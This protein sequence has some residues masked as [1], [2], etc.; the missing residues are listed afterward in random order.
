MI[1]YPH[2]LPGHLV[3]RGEITKT[4]IHCNPDSMDIT[5]IAVLELSRDSG[6][7][8]HDHPHDCEMYYDI[9]KQHEEICMQGGRHWVENTTAKKMYVVS[10]KKYPGAWI[11]KEATEFEKVL[12]FD[13]HPK[14]LAEI[15]V[16]MLSPGSTLTTANRPYSELFYNI[17]THHCDFF[18]VNHKP[19]LTNTTEET[20][21]ILSVKKADGPWMIP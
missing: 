3:E 12:F 14:K 17:K 18:P 4:I 2:P 21:Y 15:S 19:Q 9:K 6:I 5:E 13:P 8:P 7:W 1:L 10:I 11:L 20:I 16:I